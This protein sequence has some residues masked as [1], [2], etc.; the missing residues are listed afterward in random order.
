LAYVTIAYAGNVNWGG[1][2]GALWLTSGSA[3]LSYVTITES[4]TLG[5]HSRS[6]AASSFDNVTVSNC[7]SHGLLVQGNGAQTGLNT[8]TNSMFT[9]NGGYGINFGNDGRASITNSNITN[10]TS[11]AIGTQPH[12]DILGLT[13]LTVSGNGGGAKN[14]I[15]YRGGTISARNE[16]WRYGS[17]L[18]YLVTGGVIV[19]TGR[20]LNVEDRNVIRFATQSSLNVLGNYP[21]SARVPQESRSRR[22][23]RRQLVV[24]GMESIS[25]AVRIRRAS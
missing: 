10:N 21:Q 5:I 6:T 11:Y 3:T 23:A 14:A 19:A 22:T 24:R 1:G 16:T 2:G 18:P 20:V 8:I 15:S 7:T 9:T 12:T 17:G 4:S 13:G 25:T